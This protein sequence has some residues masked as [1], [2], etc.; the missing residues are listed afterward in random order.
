[1]QKHHGNRRK[2]GRVGEEPLRYVPPWSE[3]FISGGIRLC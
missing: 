1:M 3:E 2:T